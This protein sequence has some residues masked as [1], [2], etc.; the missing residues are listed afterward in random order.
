MELKY[1]VLN[2]N[3]NE[4][5]FKKSHNEDAGIDI[6]VPAQDTFIMAHP[7][8]NKIPLGISIEVPEG[9]MG[10]LYPRSGTTVRGLISLQ[11]PIDRGYSGEIHLL[12]LNTNRASVVINKDERLCQLVLVKIA[13]N[14]DTIKTESIYSGN[15]NDK[16]FNS[17]GR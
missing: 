2:K 17:S 13:E 3:F 16:A 14:V 7:G 1:V 4:R 10:I 12:L 6:P 5:L 9:Y 15:R 11:P 8:V